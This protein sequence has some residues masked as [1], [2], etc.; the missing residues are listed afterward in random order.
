[1]EVKPIGTPSGV[2]STAVTRLPSRSARITE[3]G[4]HYRVEI[5]RERS[6]QLEPQP[7]GDGEVVAARHGA[8]AP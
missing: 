5:V 2:L 7:D 3:L 6:R 4:G 1:M 8:G